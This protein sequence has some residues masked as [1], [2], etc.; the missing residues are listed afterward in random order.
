[1]NATAQT[2]TGDTPSVLEAS[3]GS[4]P[5]RGKIYAKNIMTT[6]VV[7]VNPDTTVR[8]IARLLS[9]NR[10]S[11]V[12]VVAG[13]AL[14]GIVTEGDLLRREEL[15]T[16][17]P[18]RAAVRDADYVKQHGRRAR[19][20]MTPDVVTVTEQTSLTEIAEMMGAKHIKRVPVMRSGRLVGIVSR[21]DIVRT[22]VARPNGSHGP[23]ICDD[24]IVRFKVIETLMNIPGASAW[25]T[26]VM[27]S[28]GV[29]ELSGVV[30]DEAVRD[31][32]RRALEQLPCVV[33]VNDHRCIL[34]PYWG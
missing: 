22:L 9:E 8:D 1:M 29:V 31:P 12:P 19:D 21:E 3:V 23:L 14:V 7:A 10:F 20:V 2:P 4:I 16:D 30:Q 27:V 34:Q 18:D 28:N 26:D 15:G 24:D 25:L 11:A 6:D 33:A 13:T 17:T 5:D 32:S